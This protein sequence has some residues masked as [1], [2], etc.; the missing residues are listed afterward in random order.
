MKCK[1]HLFFL[2]GIFNFASCGKKTLVLQ[3]AAGGVSIVSSGTLRVR[4]SSALYD[5][6]EKFVV[7]KEKDFGGRS[8]D[9]V[10]YFQPM[11]ISID[12]EKLFYSKLKFEFEKP[13]A[14]DG[15]SVIFFRPYSYQK[16]N[17]SGFKLLPTD[18]GENCSGLE[19]VPPAKEGDPTTQKVVPVPSFCFGGPA[20]DLVKDFP[21]FDRLFSTKSQLVAV[22]G[23]VTKVESDL[24][25]GVDNRYYVNDMQDISRNIDVPN[26]Y[27]AGTM[28]DYIAWC[29]DVVGNTLVK[30][31]IKIQDFN[32]QSPNP[33]ADQF[34]SWTS[35]NN[36]CSRW[37]W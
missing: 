6:P 26:L 17:T 36:N 18:K 12:E 8:T 27:V 11:D 19:D 14:E 35:N 34:C 13:V 24:N 9:A 16:S 25:P 30:V 22:E 29:D 33:T 7:L 37:P 15:C 4:V 2:I 20:K 10:N 28:K 32:G 21:R 23:K 31:R 3:G 1:A 5:T